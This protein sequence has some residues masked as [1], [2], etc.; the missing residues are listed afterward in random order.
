[1]PT[2][3][4]PL[5]SCA[6][7]AYLD[8][9]ATAQKPQSVIDA[10][11][12]FYVHDNANPY[13]SLYP[14]A[15]RATEAYEAARGSIAKFIGAKTPSCLAFTSGTTMSI[16]VVAHAWAKKNLQKGD[17]ILSTIM[18][19]HANIV[20]WQN[21]TGCDSGLD[22]Q[23]INMY[24][25]GILDLEDM[26]A[27]F[28]IFNVKLVCVTHVSNVLGTLNP[29]KEIVKMAHRYKA[30]VLVDGAQAIGHMPVNVSRLGVD[31]Y[32][33]S[34]HKMLGPMG[35]GGLYIAPQRHA[36]MGIMFA[37]G[38]MI[39]RVTKK[40]AWFKPVPYR[41]EAGTQSVADIIGLE[42]ATEYLNNFPNGLK[43]VKT[44]INQ[45][46][47]YAWKKLKKIPN[48]K[49]LGPGPGKDWASS[50][51]SFTFDHDGASNGERIKNQDL[52]TELGKHGIYVRSGLFCAQPLIEERLGLKGAVRVSLHLYNTVSDIDRLIEQLLLITKK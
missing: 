37:G 45:L 4:F 9:S 12:N 32:A 21:I 41:L 36:E 51:I 16:N 29:I 46:G 20:P 18:E 27:R 50:V 19:H 47:K 49:L 22:L 34:G 13:R 15:E 35:S 42:A 23:L 11:T 7:F 28:K 52:A 30:A 33:F 31:F 10:V 24:D 8:S 44:Y 26:E 17:T 48:I 39:S 14:L 1:M 25:N 3:D 5:L 38:D 6:A 2:K 43:G 40:K